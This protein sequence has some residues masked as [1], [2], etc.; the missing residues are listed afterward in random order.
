[1]FH[2]YSGFEEGKGET[3]VRRVAFS[4]LIG[5]GLLLQLGGCDSCKQQP[6]A[7]LTSSIGSGSEPGKP[8]EVK[9]HKTATGDLYWV[10]SVVGTRGLTPVPADLAS[11]SPF[12]ILCPTPVASSYWTNSP[13]VSPAPLVEID[14]KINSAKWTSCQT[15]PSERTYEVK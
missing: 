6:P 5:F 1:M 7:A 12:C 10:Y 13:T 2:L 14:L 11:G 9:P 3:I 15:C 4:A 8:M